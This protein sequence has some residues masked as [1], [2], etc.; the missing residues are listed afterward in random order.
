VQTVG[1]AA[2]AAAP[3]RQAVRSIDPRQPVFDVRTMQEFYQLRAVNLMQ[4]IVVLVGAMGIVGLCLA[5]VGLYGLV[6]YSVSRQTREIGIRMAIGAKW[7]DIL[8]LVLRQG[9]VLAATGVAAGIVGGLGLMRVL[10]SLFDRTATHWGD[11]WGLIA[12]PIVVLTVTAAACYIPA[13]RAAA[14][15][16]NQ[17]LHYE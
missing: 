2:S 14:I 17:A 3:V 4:M 5:M 7:S 6:A 13:R 1:D 9:L 10:A 12:M 15:D 11:V 8:R 16:A